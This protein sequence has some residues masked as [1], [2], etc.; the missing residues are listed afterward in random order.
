MN[1]TK[2][3]F[4]LS[5]FILGLG[6]CTNQQAMNNQPKLSNLLYQALDTNTMEAM[7]KFEQVIA[8]EDLS[9]GDIVHVDHIDMGARGRLDILEMLINS[10]KKVNSQTHLGYNASMLLLKNCKRKQPDMLRLLKIL[11]DKGENVN[12]QQYNGPTSLSIAIEKDCYEIVKFL[13]ESGANKNAK[14]TVCSCFLKSMRHDY[15]QVTATDLAKTMGKIDIAKYLID[16]PK[17]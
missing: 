8:K 5:L 3:I 15:V 4:L 12:H 11:L 17:N 13:I 10:Y 9:L 14:Y 1:Y 6:L 16:E 2:N 7:K